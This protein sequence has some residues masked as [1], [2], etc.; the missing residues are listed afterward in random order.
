MVDDSS[1][2]YT[3]VW[4]V[5]I[6]SWQA[7]TGDSQQQY[8]PSHA[9]PATTIAAGMPHAQVG[10]SA[11]YNTDRKPFD[12]WLGSG[13]QTPFSPNKANT[14]INQENDLIVNNTDGLTF[15]QNQSD[16][17]EALLPNNVLG[18]AVSTTSNKTNMSAG[19]MP[20]YRTDG[21]G[22][23]EA[24]K[25]IGVYDVRS[26]ADQSHGALSHLEQLMRLDREARPNCTTRR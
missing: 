14:N 1:D 4:P 17:C 2:Q 8:T 15:V 3:L 20:G 18:V 21:N 25:L 12:C 7:R 5:P 26:Q 9:D 10:T 16:F 11:L 23:K 22:K 24:A 6:L 13:G 19:F